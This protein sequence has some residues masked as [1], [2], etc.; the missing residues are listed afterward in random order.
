MAFFVSYARQFHRRLHVGVT[1]KVIRRAIGDFA[2]AWGYSFDV[3]VQWRGRRVVLG[4]TLQ[5]ASTMLQSWSVNP[6]AFTINST[7]P[8]T[9]QPYTFR[10]VFAQELPTG[11]TFLVL[12]VLRLGSGLVL[13]V[14]LLNTLTFGLDGDI[15][16]DGQQA[17]AFNAGAV[18]FHP[19]VGAEFSF[20]QVLALRVGLNRI[21]RTDR[22][23]LNVV[24]SVGT[25][26]R[27]KSLSIDYGF[28]DFGGLASELGFSH[29]ISVHFSLER[30]GL[31][32]R[33][34]DGS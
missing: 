28:G 34:F 1:G 5:D 23:G 7:N 16:F 21:D 25:G 9:G 12:P 6:S 27:L 10:E 30:E 3:G 32:R 14:G 17:N 24:P 4:A 2:D 15:A 31:R 26:L 18:S 19:R 11:E 13:P 29:R 8:D 20:R 33:G 22:Y